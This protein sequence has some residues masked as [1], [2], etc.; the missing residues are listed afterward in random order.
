V[1]ELGID[2]RHAEVL[3]EQDLASVERVD[4]SGA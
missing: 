4:P 2:A 3:V 1:V